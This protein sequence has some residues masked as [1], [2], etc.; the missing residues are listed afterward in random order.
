MSAWRP[1]LL[2]A[3]APYAGN[4]RKIGNRAAG[5]RRDDRPL[6]S[7]SLRLQHPIFRQS[8]SRSRVRPAIE[9]EWIVPSRNCITAA[10]RM[11]HGSL[12]HIRADRLPA[13]QHLR[14]RYG[15]AASL[16]CP[17]DSSQ[18]QMRHRCPRCAVARGVLERANAHRRIRISP[19]FNAESCSH[20][21]SA[22]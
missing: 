4:R 15:A 2:V 21:R 19:Q 5:R 20:H 7:F 11:L 16:R 17:P 10:E 12:V 14:S 13:P 3:Y 9:G 22:R 8:G 6:R 18:Q 1:A